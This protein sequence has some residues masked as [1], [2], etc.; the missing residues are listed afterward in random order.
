[1]DRDA[2]GFDATG[3]DRVA[4]EAERAIG[5]DRQDGDL[6]LP[7][8]TARTYRPW[9]AT[10]IAPCDPTIVPVPAPPA[11]NGEPASA[12]SEPSACWAK[13]PIVFVSAVLS[14][15]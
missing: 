9:L 8:S 2:D 10:W 1:M 15:T 13:P 7:A 14:F 12:V 11:E 3:G 6:V 5:S 4:D